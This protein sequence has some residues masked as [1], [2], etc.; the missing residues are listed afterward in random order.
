MAQTVAKAPYGS[1]RGDVRDGIARYLGIPYAAPPTGERRFRPAEGREPLSGTFDAGRYGPASPQHGKGWSDEAGC[2]TLNIWAPENARRLPVFFFI[3]G[4]SFVY[5]SGS[6]S[7]YEGSHLAREGNMIVVTFNYRLG[8]L[9]CLDFSDLDSRFASNCA[10]TDMAAALQ[11]VYENIEAFGGD[12]EQITVAGQSAGAISASAFPVNRK[13]NHMVS[14]VIMM[15][16]TPTYLRSRKENREISQ[17]FFEYTGFDD[18]QKLLSEDAGRL[19]EM[20]WNF[21]S[22]CGMGEATYSLAV[23]G[24][25]IPVSPVAAAAEGAAKSIPIFMGTT[26]EELAFVT[27]PILGGALGIR[28]HIRRSLR[29]EDPEVL[30]ALRREY[31][32]QFGR[33][34]NS[35]FIADRV[36]RMGSLWYAQAYSAFAPAWLYRFDFESRAMQVIGLRA[37]HSSDLPLFFGNIST[38]IFPY[39][40]LLDQRQKPHLTLMSEMQKDVFRFVAEGELPWD[41]CTPDSV[42]AKIYDRE[43]RYADAMEGS[44]R[45]AFEQTRFYAETFRPPYS[46]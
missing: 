12:P 3:H 26:Q 20:G 21:Q 25:T 17:R 34:G 29:E 32:R 33:R 27:S 40:Y 16:G 31:S 41:G 46:A 36:F 9:G 2:L 19:A 18:P 4:G 5:G 6:Q 11:W 39:M 45:E 1:I 44:I 37:C 42:P 13:L 30:R 23:D 8:A 10:F 38:G 28:G 43:I 22:V 24:E 7:L 14:K 35:V 15:S